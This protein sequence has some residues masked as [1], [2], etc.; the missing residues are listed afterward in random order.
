MSE[1]NPKNRTVSEE[2]LNDFARLHDAIQDLNLPADNP[3]RIYSYK[4][5]FYLQ[6]KAAA[7]E[8]RDKFQRE[9]ANR[10]H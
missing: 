9:R 5:L 10:A 4:M 8:R 3:V 7:M 2:F 6:E 1:G